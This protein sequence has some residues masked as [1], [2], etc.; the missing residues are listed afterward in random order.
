M[1]ASFGLI[2]RGQLRQGQTKVISKSNTNLSILAYILHFL[3]VLRDGV[4]ERDFNYLYYVDAMY[5]IY[6]NN[7]PM[8]FEEKTG[9]QKRFDF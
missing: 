1:M 4:L 3:G 2:L 9:S 6:V 8:H 7:T 5:F